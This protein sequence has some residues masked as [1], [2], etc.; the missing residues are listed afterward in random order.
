MTATDQAAEFA[1]RIVDAFL[2]SEPGEGT[3]LAQMK[4]ARVPFNEACDEFAMMIGLVS[5][6][7]VE[8]QAKTSIRA[9]R[10]RDEAV[11]IL[12]AVFEDALSI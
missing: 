10:D 7:E 12:T 4:A 11:E 6:E 1:A 2:A 8:L 5:G 9:G 3:T